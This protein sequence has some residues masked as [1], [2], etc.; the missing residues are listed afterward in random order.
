MAKNSGRV[1]IIYNI[2]ITQSNFKHFLSYFS[3][4]EVVIIVCVTEHDLLPSGWCHVLCALYIPEAWFGNVQT[5]E[6]I[7][8]KGVPAERF[9]KV[10]SSSS[11]CFQCSAGFFELTTPG[12]L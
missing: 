2:H 10:H 5:M 6:P 3:S 7:V 11:S 12:N 9:N 1:A 4:V 8:L